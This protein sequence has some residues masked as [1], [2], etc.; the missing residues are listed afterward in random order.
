MLANEFNSLSIVPQAPG[1]SC[2]LVKMSVKFCSP[3]KLSPSAII[4]VVGSMPSFLRNSDSRTDIRMGM[5]T[6]NRMT[7]MVGEMSSRARVPWPSLSGFFFLFVGAGVSA[8]VAGVL[9]FVVAGVS[10]TVTPPWGTALN[11]P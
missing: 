10:A 7:A 9:A 8:L 2:G 1:T 11:R 3:T 5:P 4:P 6:T